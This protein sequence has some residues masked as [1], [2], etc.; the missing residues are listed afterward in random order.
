MVGTGM[1]DVTSSSNEQGSVLASDSLRVKPAEH[2]RDATAAF[3]PGVPGSNPGL[4]A[5]LAPRV[6]S[7]VQHDQPQRHDSYRHGAAAP[8][9]WRGSTNLLD[10]SGPTPPHRRACGG[11]G[12][13]SPDGQEGR[14]TA[15]ESHHR[16]EQ[17][18]PQ[19][20]RSDPSCPNQSPPQRGT[21][22]HDPGDPEGGHG[23]AAE[24]D[25]G[26][27]WRHDGLRQVCQSLLPGCEGERAPVLRVGK[28]GVSGGKHLGVPEALRAVPDAAKGHGGQER[29]DEVQPV[30][31]QSEEGTQG[32]PGEAGDEHNDT[33]LGFSEFG[34]R[35]D[36]EPPH[37]AGGRTHRRGEDVEGRACHGCAPQDCSRH[38]GVDG[39][40]SQGLP[41]SQVAA[42][43]IAHKS[44][45]VVPNIFEELSG[46]N[47]VELMEFACEPDSLLASAVQ[48]RTG[49]SDAACRSSLWCGHDLSTPAGLSQVLEQIQVLR[50][51]N[52]WISP[53]C[54]PY[55]PLQ[56][57]NQRS[58]AQIRELKVK[59]ATAQR[60]YGS[61]L[62]I[63][64]ICLQLGIHITV[65]LAERC[66]AWR[67]PIFQ[68]LR[69][70][71]GLHTAV[72]KGCSVGLKGQDGALM[73]KG[74]RIVTSHARLSEVMHKPCNCHTGYRHAKC[75]GK[76]ATM[77]ARYTKEY[78]RLAVEALSREGDV[79]RIVEECSGKSQLPQGFGLGLMCTCSEVE[80]QCGSCL[81]RDEDVKQDPQQPQAFMSCH[82][83]AELQKQAQELQRHPHKH[84]LKDLELLLHQHPLTNLGKT[85]RNE[86]ASQDYLVFGS[87]AFG[88]HYGV[89]SKT[90]KCS[91]LCRYVNKVLRKIMP[92]HLKWT[93]FAL[94]H[95]T[96][97][98]IH[99]DYN[100][101]AMHPNGS[102]G[103]G[104]YKG[105]ELWVEG[106]EGF[107]GRQGKVSVRENSHG[108]VLEGREFDVKL[109]P[110]VFSPKRRHGTCDWEG[111]RWV[112][113]VFVSRNWQALSSEECHVL[114]D[115]GFPIPKRSHEEGFPAEHKEGPQH[116]REVER[117]KKQLYLLHC[118]TGHSNPKHME[119][120]LQKRGADS[121]TLELAKDFSCPVCQEKCKPQPRHLAALEPL[122]P[123]LATISA[124]VGHWVNPHTQE[125]VQFMLVIDEG[126]RFRTARILSQGSRQS[127]NAQTCLHYLQEGWVQY[128]GLPRCLRLD[129][130]GVFRSNAVE[131]WCD[132]HGIF[133]DI[134][135][136]EAHWKVGTCENAIQGV[137]NVMDKLTLHDENVT[138]REALAEAVTTFNHKELVRDS[139]LRSIFWDRP[140]ETGRFL[141]ASQQLPPDLLVEH[142]AGEFE[143]AVQRRAEAEKALIE[144]N[145]TQRITRAMNSR[146]RPSYNYRPGE[147][148]FY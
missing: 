88:N 141:P 2:H 10:P 142:P 16:V 30:E 86:A 113:T 123:K 24:R 73:Q 37:P 110:L 131:E 90:Q 28:D 9:L 7:Q 93:S 146:H 49:R 147:L 20:G 6:P 21:Q 114:E 25:C 105:G 43:A 51:K 8:D 65:E 104:N 61:T 59:R 45:V 48:A 75:E 148:V 32:D 46:V 87:Y 91:E 19:E 120:A 101:D 96:M 36:G 122:P 13:R 112:I 102:V 35:G 12:D 42:S 143:R 50:P 85:R 58:P 138:S 80:G 71:M 5:N 57:V 97:M 132:K 1:G 39:Q 78:V 23:E 81:L 128:F 119:Q 41:M 117:I 109:R 67:L 107:D 139:H 27:G 63:V 137:K 82:N 121:L 116:A 136:G 135:P 99:T 4:P 92:Q 68:K 66:E 74:W 79:Q 133:L 130:A 52:V 118:A 124:D 54:G 134:V 106:T 129:P 53:P 94:N 15:P 29:T 126:S 17:G 98:P 144:W 14:N 76:N 44:Q 103:F 55:S 100:N 127:P 140:D 18:Q 47:R 83:Q 33:E 3:D 56:N 125:S 145:A 40:P 26:R 84:T 70:E 111:D 31:A 22:C 115:L 38:G 60:I 108:E 64:K 11:Q 62:E 69:F 89:T 95:G 34:L 72:T 77:S